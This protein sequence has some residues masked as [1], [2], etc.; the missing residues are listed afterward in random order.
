MMVATGPWGDDDER[1]VL[2]IG[3]TQADMD[4]LTRPGPIHIDGDDL[5]EYG[6]PAVEII[7]A[8]GRT[9]G[10]IADTIRAHGVALGTLRPDT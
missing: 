7:V 5:A 8:Y 2:F 4:H 10:D 3:L 9:E 1:R 6:L